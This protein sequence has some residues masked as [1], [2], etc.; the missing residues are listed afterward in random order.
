MGRTT[1]LYRGRLKEREGA[2]PLDV[3]GCEQSG[4]PLFFWTAMLSIRRRRG[5]LCSAFPAGL[6]QWKDFWGDAQHSFGLAARLKL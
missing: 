4:Q 5:S 1:Q 3:V 2:T 6:T